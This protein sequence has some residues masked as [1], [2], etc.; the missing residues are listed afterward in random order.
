[1]VTTDCGKRNGAPSRANAVAPSA[2]TTAM[3]AKA[4]PKA[5]RTEIVLVL[6]R[7]GSSMNFHDR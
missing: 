6:N 2:P 3:L 7:N 4:P 5:D 1:M